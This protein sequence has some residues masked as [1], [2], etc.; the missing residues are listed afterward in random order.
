MS[1]YGYS[2]T[3][4][5]H[6]LLIHTHTHHSISNLIYATTNMSRSHQDR[7]K[8]QSRAIKA[9]KARMSCSFSLISLS[10]SAF[11]LLDSRM[12][13]LLM[14]LS[15]AVPL[16]SLCLEQLCALI[17]HLG[18]TSACSL[19][20]CSSRTAVRRRGASGGGGGSPRS[21]GG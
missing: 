13:A 2:H 8:R 18:V 1:S 5:T 20:M 21:L 17:C 10:R 7:K 12:R 14:L 9:S 16:V 11:N 15:R 6:T 4:F 19:S 3:T